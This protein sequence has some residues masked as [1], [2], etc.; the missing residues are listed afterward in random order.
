MKSFI[1]LPKAKKGDQVAIVS[2]A[3][4]LPDIFPWVQD[5]GIKRLQ[6]VF[7]LKG[8]EYPTTRLMGSS[9]QDRARD[10]MDAFRD[11]A[12]KAVIASIGGSD[13][14]KILKHLDPEVFK[15]SPK[16]FFGYSDNT[17]FIQFLWNLGIPA[18]YGGGLMNQFAFHGSMQELTVE[19]IR[20]AMFESGEFEIRSSDMYNDINISW[21]LEDNLQKT[22]QMEPN[23]GWYWDGD[24]DTEGTLWGGCVESM[25][26][27]FATGR[28]LPKDEDLDGTV[29]FLETAEDLPEPWIV[30]YVLTG[31]GERGWF[32]KFQAVLIGRPKAWGF[33]KRLTADEKTAYRKSQRDTILRVVREYNSHIP[34]IQNIDFGHT[35]PQIVVPSG[36]RAR[37]DGTEHRIFFN[38]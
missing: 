21:D 26:I 38:Y 19:F 13:Q 36:Q 3:A 15:S 35:D 4:G 9:P 8:I 17:H 22:R 18:Y 25:V 27:Q 7:G 30:D 23:D 32:D 14:I 6:A 16:P 2:P 34:V 24:Q 31:M 11:P 10:L 20:R 37:I 5:L 1:S 33:D 12:N 29:L 28:W